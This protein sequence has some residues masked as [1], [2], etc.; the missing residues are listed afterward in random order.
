MAVLPLTEGEDVSP[1]ARIAAVAARQ[2][3]AF[4]RAQALRA[5]LTPHAISHRRRSGRWLDLHRAAYA[6]AGSPTEER[7]IMAAVLSLGE[8]AVI[9]SLAAHGCT[10]GNAR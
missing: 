2:H 8:R 4:S 1:D 10:G 5:G 6:I 9:A 7:R 3:G